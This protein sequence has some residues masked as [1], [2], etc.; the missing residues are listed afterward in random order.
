MS[1]IK[2]VGVKIISPE[3]REEPDPSVRV[4][5]ANSVLHESP[6]FKTLGHPTVETTDIRNLNF[7][8]A[9]RAKNC[10][11]LLGGTERDDR[12]GYTHYFETMRKTTAYRNHIKNSE[13]ETREFFE[14]ETPSPQ[15]IQQALPTNIVT[16]L[17]NKQLTRST[18][19][20]K[21]EETLEPE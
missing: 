21:H 12:L 19:S 8:T 4:K 13:I 17:Y 6:K 15:N 7:V 9:T 14:G 18:D 1:R 11:G 3:L 16:R 5:F 2:E 10:N 20:S